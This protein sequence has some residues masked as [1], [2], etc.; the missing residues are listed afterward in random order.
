MLAKIQAGATGYDIVFPSVHMHDIMFKLN[1]LAKT[2]INQAA[3]WTNIDPR[4][5]NSQSDPK[6]EYCMPY[7]WGTTGIFY[8]KKLAGGDITS[9]AEFFAIPEKTSNIISVLDDMREAANEWVAFKKGFAT[10]I[11][12]RYCWWRSIGIH[13]FDGRFLK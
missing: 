13:H 9:W 11:G 7:A 10:A 6:G 8:N 1:L 12:P 4:F 3:D 5:L 2:D